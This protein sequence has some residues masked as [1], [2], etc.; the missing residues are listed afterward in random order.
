MKNKFLLLVALWCFSGVASVP[1]PSSYEDTTTFESSYTSTII[2]SQTVSSDGTIDANQLFVAPCSS[3]ST[4]GCTCTNGCT[5]GAGECS[6]KSN[7][8]C[9][10]V[11]IGEGTL[12]TSVCLKVP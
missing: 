1:S 9:A 7:H 10:P 2:Q 3:L 8:L 5:E 11:C 6:C 4:K 12:C